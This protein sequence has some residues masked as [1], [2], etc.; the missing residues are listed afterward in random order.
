MERFDNQAPIAYVT[1]HFP[2]LSQ[3]FVRNEVDAL[4]RLGRSVDVFAMNTPSTDDLR[5]DT[6]R[7]ERDRT[8]YL[9][10]SPARRVPAA[11][12]TALRVAPGP[13]LR[14]VIG[15]FGHGR[16]D[17]GAITLR[18][19]HLLEATVLWA[20]CRRRGI[21]HVHAQFGGSTA[22]IAMLAARL[23]GGLPQPIGFSFIVHGYTDFTD[24]PAIGLA[25]KVPEAEFVIAVSDFIRA[26]ILR[27]LPPDQWD[28]VVVIK[29]GIDL[30][31]FTVAD[32]TDR[33]P[34][35]IVTVGRLSSEKGQSVLLEAVAQLRSRGCS[36]ELV[37]IGD[38]PL[39]ADLERRAAE[40]GIVDLVDFRGPMAPADVLDELSRADL[41]C[42]PSFAEG[43]P[44]SIMEAMAVGLPVV[45]TSVMGIPELV[46]DGDTGYVV[47][48]G[49]P[50]LL[51]DAITRAASDTAGRAALVERARAAVA[52][53]HGAARSFERT[54][55]LFR[56]RIDR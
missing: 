43:I 2:N 5:S 14:E 56:E 55:A 1:T 3:T 29:V 22:T 53:E 6:D 18:L 9:K 28:K 32:P 38:G 26:Q 27:Q 10:A 20:A 17:L 7:A 33:V 16:L 48:P 19:V 37:V 12:L 13:F 4:R 35:R 39:R 31:R 52:A 11:V 15:S 50:D 49:R 24:E 34:G 41:F 51:A 44:V 42:L 30:D 25:A 45:T 36:P 21:T 23:S 47:T 8:T 46:R 54:E 40:L